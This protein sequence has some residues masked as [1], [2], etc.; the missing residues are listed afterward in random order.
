MVLLLILSVMTNIVAV[1]LTTVIVNISVSRC[2]TAAL[3]CNQ[4]GVVL[5]SRRHCN[6]I[7]EGGVLLLQLRRRCVAV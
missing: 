2:V 6:T 7:K 3:Y 5:L 4:G 1:N